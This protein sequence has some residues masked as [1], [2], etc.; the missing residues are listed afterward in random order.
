MHAATRPPPAF[1]GWRRLWPEPREATW[2]RWLALSPD[3]RAGL[4]PLRWSPDALKNQAER[5]VAHLMDVVT[6]EESPGHYR[7]EG[8]DVRLR[9]AGAT[10]TVET[11][12]IALW[13]LYKA[14]AR[15]LR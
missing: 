1:D 3:Q 11:F 2:H 4:L 14:W 10:W 15:H 13:A 6:G 7:V 9:G 12:D 5:G 8:P